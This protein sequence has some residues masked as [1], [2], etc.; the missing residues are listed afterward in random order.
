ML[1]HSVTCQQFV[2]ITKQIVIAAG[3]YIAWLAVSPVHA[4]FV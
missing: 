3:F 1:K 4:H 2:V